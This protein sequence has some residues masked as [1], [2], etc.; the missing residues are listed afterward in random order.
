MSR[1]W[2]V[3]VAA[4]AS[5]AGCVF[6]APIA[7]AN[8]VT[9]LCT[10]DQGQAPCTGGWY[11][12]PVLLSWTWS[13]QTGSSPTPSCTMEAQTTGNT[14]ETVTCD[15][16]WTSPPDISYPYRLE[17]ETTNPTA[18]ASAARPPDYN[19][20]YNHPVA[21]SFAGSAF[22]GISFCTPT[23]TYGGPDALNTAVSGSCTDN[24][25]KVA[26]TSLGL[27]YDATPPKMT[28]ATPSRFP[29]DNGWYNHP[30]TFTFSG[31]DAVSGIGSCATETYSGPDSA[32]AS[33]V[34]SCID[35]AGNVS[36]LSV[37]IRYDA[38][39]PTL[40][41]AANPGDRSVKLSWDA[42]GK[43]API[44]SL[45]IERTPG[46][47][48]SATSV[49]QRGNSGSYTDSQVRNWVLYR[50]TITARNEAGNVTT[51]TI[52]ITPGPR[53]LGPTNGT[54]ITNPPML[55]WTPIRNAT[56]YNVQLYRGDRKVLSTWPSH[57]KLQ[58]KHTW[59]FGGHVYR[60][61]AGKYRWYVWP[62]YGRRSAARYGSMVGKG[63]FVVTSAKS[64]ADATVVYPAIRMLAPDAR[65]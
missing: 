30:V 52:N 27:H 47:S 9:P 46:F 55:R 29:D 24:A 61:K 50:Y 35:L 23:T 41:V 42:S 7:W 49:I 31:T 13:P 1:R 32:S 19:G 43:V 36:T 14:N 39:P 2:R 20:W 34:G 28:G 54:Q 16:N 4:A 33:V 45:Q 12:E 8:S 60:F 64:A 15:V 22:S 5:M 53:L 58:L 26:N 21:V 56:Y 48:G 6:A 59:H 51:R 37:P 65:R 11:T 3:A 38:T 62:G 44:T 17:V 25:G 63:T 10:T 57:A 18:T 40:A